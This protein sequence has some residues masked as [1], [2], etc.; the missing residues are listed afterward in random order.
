MAIIRGPRGP[1][2]L[3]AADHNRRRAIAEQARRDQVGHREIVTLQ[4]QGAE[5]DREQHGYMIGK[6]RR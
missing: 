1:E 5:L 2:M 4:S 6:A 3:A